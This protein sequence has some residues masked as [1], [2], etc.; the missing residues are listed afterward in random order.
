MVNSQ[1]NLA[2]REYLW[3]AVALIVVLLLSA[4][5]VDVRTQAKAGPKLQSGTAGAA[6]VS[7]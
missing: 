7:R 2:G 5:Q 6:I 3:F 1:R 4:T